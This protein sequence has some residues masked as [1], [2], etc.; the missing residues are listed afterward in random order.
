M[1][2]VAMMQVAVI[3]CVCGYVGSLSDVWGNNS[4]RGR[5]LPSSW[6][7]VSHVLLCLHIMRSVVSTN[8]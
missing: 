2:I 1:L 5:R 4:Q 6:A 3:D 7:V 8:F